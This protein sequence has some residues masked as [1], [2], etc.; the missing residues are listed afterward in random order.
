MF[1]MGKGPSSGGATAG[2]PKPHSAS[3]R[4]RY[5]ALLRES[6]D[7]PAHLPG[8]GESLHALMTGYDDFMTPVGH[9]S[10]TRPAACLHLR[11]ATLAF[12]A[13]NTAE[14][15]G[16]L[17]GKTVHRLDLI[18]SDFFASHNRALGQ[19]ARQQLVIDRGQRLAAPRSHRKVVCLADLGQQVVP[20]G[21]RERMHAGPVPALVPVT[22]WPWWSMS[23]SQPRRW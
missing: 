2:V 13:R 1:G 8:P 16:L 10:T 4:R 12:S 11:I 3:A 19:D 14:L 9:L 5:T 23:W 17:D 7:V 6:K 20:V 15:V 18:A 21:P 22:F